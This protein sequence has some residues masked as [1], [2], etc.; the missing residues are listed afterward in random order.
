M[1]HLV[2]KRRVLMAITIK[3]TVKNNISKLYKY[4]M[5]VFASRPLC[6]KSDFIILII[7]N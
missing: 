2:N 7:F 3:D 4:E 1:N 5:C 6:F